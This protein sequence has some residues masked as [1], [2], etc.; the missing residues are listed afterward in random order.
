M[1]DPDCLGKR[2]KW[3]RSGARIEAEGRDDGI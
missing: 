2:P 1:Q 3:L